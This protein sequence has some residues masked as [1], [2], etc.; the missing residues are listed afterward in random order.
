MLCGIILYIDRTHVDAFRNW[1]LEP[2]SMS[3]TLFKWATRNQPNAWRQLGFIND[4]HLSSVEKERMRGMFPNASIRNFHSQVEAILGSLVKVQ[5]EFGFEM[6][7]RI[8]NLVKTVHVYCPVASAIGDCQGSDK[9]CGQYAG[10]PNVQRNRPPKAWLSSQ[11]EP[12]WMVGSMGK[13]HSSIEDLMI[14]PSDTS[15]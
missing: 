12:P 6:D 8:G 3:C 9:L 13:V 4:L 11:M 5:E 14:T 7:M 1:I 15:G 2:V 10:K